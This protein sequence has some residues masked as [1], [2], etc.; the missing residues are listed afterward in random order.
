MKLWFKRKGKQ[1][2]K[3]KYI[4]WVSWFRKKGQAKERALFPGPTWNKVK[5]E[6]GAV[7]LHVIYI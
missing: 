3:I 5:A 2:D 6:Y 1:F 7:C 4:D